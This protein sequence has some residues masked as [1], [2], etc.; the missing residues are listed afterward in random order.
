MRKNKL[1]ILALAT[2]TIA[3]ASPV[4]ASSNIR[5]AINNENIALTDAAPYMANGRTYVPIRVVSENL[6]AKVNW[7]AETSTFEVSMDKVHIIGEVNQSKVLVN[8]EETAIDSQNVGVTAT[9]RN[10]RVYVPI[11]FFAETTGYN[12]NYDNAT[13]SVYI[14]DTDTPIKPLPPVEKPNT[15]SSKVVYKTG[16]N[17]KDFIALVPDVVEGTVLAPLNLNASLEVGD[18][19]FS[20]TR[21]NKYAEEEK[22]Y[23]LKIM[24]WGWG[25]VSQYSDR[26]QGWHKTDMRCM[27]QVLPMITV[28]AERVFDEFYDAILN[29]EDGKIITTSDGRTIKVIKDMILIK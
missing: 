16:M 10:G 8:K 3:S 24:Y 25:P 26:G 21:P 13:N 2:L 11:R 20:V 7:V 4:M 28:E 23:N 6:G 12:V 14:N 9:I 22:G 27:Q 15:D 1:G 17:N 18:G 29:Q 19:S 5:I